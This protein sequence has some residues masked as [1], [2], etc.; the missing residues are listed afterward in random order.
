MAGRLCQLGVFSSKFLQGKTAVNIARIPSRNT[1]IYTECGGV[2]AKPDQVRLG[3]AKVFVIVCPFVYIGATISK[4]GA[5][6]L[7]END[8]FVPA[9]DDD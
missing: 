4:N 1:Q 5:A 2:C 3:L 6:F 9:D 8:I 7:E